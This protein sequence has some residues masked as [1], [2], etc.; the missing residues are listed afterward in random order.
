MLF[1]DV[2]TR[3]LLLLMG[4]SKDCREFICVSG[5]KGE[6][7]KGE[8]IWIFLVCVCVML[9]VGPHSANRQCKQTLFAHSLHFSN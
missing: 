6:M 2:L 5:E 8:G 7:V 4:Y 9:Y 3:N 1:N